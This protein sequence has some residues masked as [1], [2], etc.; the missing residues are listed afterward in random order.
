MKRFLVSV[1]RA[2]LPF[3]LAMGLVFSF[4]TDWR[5]GVSLGALA[6]L[7]F[8]LGIAVFQAF[9]SRRFQKNRP[10]FSGEQLL[11]EG[12]A[13]HFRRG[14]GVGGWLFLTSRRLLFR[15]HEINLQ[16]HELDLPLAEIAEAS[17]VNTAWLIPN[18]LLVRTASG[19]TE[20]FVVE[21]HK[22]WSTEIA[23]AARG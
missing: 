16:Q 13:N 22:R 12:P 3:G 23:R 21:Q 9:Q 18:G 20:R 10:D 17:A 7:M 8:G 2:G 4:M 14:E 15:S 1:L 19:T 6:G 11:R 5:M